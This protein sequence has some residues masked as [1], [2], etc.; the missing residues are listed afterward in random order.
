MALSSE[1]SK[2]SSTLNCNKHFPQQD[3]TPQVR[4]VCLTA[5][6]HELYYRTR[7][8]SPKALVCILSKFLVFVLMGFKIALSYLNTLLDTLAPGNQLENL[9]LEVY[10]NIL[11]VFNKLFCTVD[12]RI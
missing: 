11:V 5:Q 3:T 2:L 6:F 8:F 10:K 12:P 9:T 7:E 1:P 4:S